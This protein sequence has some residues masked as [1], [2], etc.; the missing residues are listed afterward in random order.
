MNRIEALQLAR[1]IKYGP[2]SNPEKF[3]YPSVPEAIQIIEACLKIT[4]HV[5]LTGE[6]ALESLKEKSTLVQAKRSKMLV[7]TI[8][9]GGK[10]VNSLGNVF[11]FEAPEDAGKIEV[12]HRG[13]EN[14]YFI[15]KDDAG[16]TF[17]GFCKCLSAADRDKWLRPG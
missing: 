2:G 16:V 6:A 12:T 15:F 8:F 3:A 17:E 11:E 13:D 14:L 10:S 1:Q 9:V 5:W 7:S 4:P